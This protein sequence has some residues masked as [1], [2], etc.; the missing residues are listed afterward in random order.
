MYFVKGHRDYY[1]LFNLVDNIYIIAF[2]VNLFYEIYK[3]GWVDV[4]S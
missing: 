1:T 3:D 2:K 4:L